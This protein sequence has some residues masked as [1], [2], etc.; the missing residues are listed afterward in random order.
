MQFTV[1]KQAA[2]E[3]RF[4]GG[5]ISENGLKNGILIRVYK[6]V[7]DTALSEAIH[8]DFISDLGED[9]SWDI[10]YQCKD[11]SN[12][13]I[14]ISQIQGIILPLLGVD[15]PREKQNDIIQVYDYALKATIDKKV[16]SYP[17]LM[18]KRIGVVWQNEV[19]KS[20]RL[21]KN[22]SFYGTQ[23]V[24]KKFCD[25]ETR[26]TAD[27]KIKGLPATLIDKYLKTLKDLNIPAKIKEGYLKEIGQED[28]HIMNQAKSQPKAQSYIPGSSSSTS[29][30]ND[31]DDDIPF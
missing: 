27:E 17:Q 25:A 15:Q 6:K 10:Y 9:G 3:E 19:F 8:F 26:Q 1:D 12:N 22:G 31:F 21:M 5:R 23:F 30:N 16:T 7:S 13:D 24:P 29:N 11:G 20:D 4:F 18:N 14:G 2:S 28:E